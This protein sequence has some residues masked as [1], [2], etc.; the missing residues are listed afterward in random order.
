MRIRSWLECGC[1]SLAYMRLW[2]G[3]FARSSRNSPKVLTPS[4]NWLF[5]AQSFDGIHT[6]G[7]DGGHHAAHQAHGGEDQRGNDQRAR[8]D[9]EADVAGFRVLRHRAVKGEASNG[10]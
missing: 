7:A 9:D 1:C 5:V 6:R 4:A 3:G 2:A 8:S 10:K